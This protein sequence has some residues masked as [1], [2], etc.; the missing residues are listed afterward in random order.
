MVKEEKG[1]SFYVYYLTCFASVGGLLIGYHIGIISGS[2]LLIG[3]LWKLETIWKEA[4]V[5]ATI[6]AAAVFALL[7]GYL[8]DLLGRKRVIMLASFV[9]TAGAIIMAV[10][11][12]IVVLLVG[13]LIVGVGI[14]FAAV[15]IPIYVAEAAPRNIRGRL[16]HLTYLSVTV[17]FLVSS[18]VGGLLITD[19][20]NGWRYM[21]G[22]AGVPSVI[23]FIGFFLLPESPR[24]L[25]SRNRQEQAR[26]VLCKIR[27]MNNVDTELN[28]IILSVEEDRKT[29]A[30]TGCRLAIVRV[31]A[32][33]P[34][35]RAFIIGCTLHILQHI[36][37]IN[38]VTYYSAGILKRVGFPTEMAI[39]MMCVPS[40]AI[41]LATFI[42]VCLVEKI[43]RRKLIL[44]SMLGVMISLVVFT[45]GFHLSSI[46]TLSINT[47]AIDILDNESASGE[48][49]QYN[50]CEACLDNIYC[51]FCYE[52]GK[53]LTTGTCLRVDET[54]PERYALSSSRCNKT[55]ADTER[56]KRKF[57]WADS[58]CPSDYAWMAVLGLALFVLGFA[59]GLGPMPWTINSEIYPL[60]A[61]STCVSIATVTNWVFSFIVSENFLTL[62]EQITIYGTFGLFCGIILLGLFVLFFVIPE[63]KN[64]WLEDVEELFMSEE[65]KIMHTRDKFI[66]ETK[67]TTMQ[68]HSINEVISDSFNQDHQNSVMSSPAITKF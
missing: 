11:K 26:K 6:G 45:V 65:Y 35:R 39:W 36:C 8:T 10:A 33:Q 5:S 37:G 22:L 53:P 19:T 2:L 66:D 12:G 41:C 23:Q 52:E 13:R 20:E 61:R 67:G 38:V 15:S 17:G 49:I 62:T 55:N 51:G 57:H 42:G 31:F 32:T 44:I 43:G 40:A 54:F 9:F 24:W 64:K 48:C 28:E 46:H 68:T 1:S 18:I 7:A 59:L 25:V 47:T 58:Y 14:G 50:T 27:S 30:T 21:L 34:V 4:I 29:L 3:D 60:W 63:P 16:V 56:S